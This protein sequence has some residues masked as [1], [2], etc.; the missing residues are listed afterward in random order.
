M[1]CPSIQELGDSELCGPF[2]HGLCDSGKEELSDGGAVVSAQA[3]VSTPAPKSAM[4]VLDSPIAA[5][6]TSSPEKGEVLI[7]Y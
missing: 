2:L 6:A 4:E 5:I 3:T 7:I 1:L